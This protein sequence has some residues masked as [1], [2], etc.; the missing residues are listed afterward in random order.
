MYFEDEA[1]VL[2]ECQM[3]R[4]E[5]LDLH[6]EVCRGMADLLAQNMNGAEQL[7]ALLASHSPQDWEALGRFLARVRQKRRKHRNKLIQM[8][9]RTHVERAPPRLLTCVHYRSV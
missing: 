7:A 6:N 8:Q 2:A 4:D 3:Y 9:T 5:R 1:H